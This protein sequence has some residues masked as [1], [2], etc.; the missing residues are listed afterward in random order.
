MTVRNNKNKII[1]FSYG[2]DNINTMKVESHSFTY[3]KMTTEQ[4]YAHFQIP[5]IKNLLLELSN[6]TKRSYTKKK[7]QKKDLKLIT[8]SIIK[9]YQLKKR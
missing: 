3:C 6:Y 5:K 2:D 7:K 4:L 1:Q 9:I 8:K